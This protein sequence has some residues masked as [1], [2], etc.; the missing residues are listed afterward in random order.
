MNCHQSR[1]I[2]SC[3]AV[4]LWQKETPCIDAWNAQRDHLA[5]RFRAVTS[6]VRTSR[7]IFRYFYIYLCTLSNIHHRKIYL[8]KLWRVLTH[9][10][11]PGCVWCALS[12]SHPPFPLSSWFRNLADVLFLI[13]YFYFL[14]SWFRSWFPLIFLLQQRRGL[15]SLSVLTLWGEVVV[16]PLPC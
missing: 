5:R 3:I 13:C 7:S 14:P 8:R 10:A 4:L 11:V 6:P 1:T 12:L 2:S 16:F 15:S 9:A